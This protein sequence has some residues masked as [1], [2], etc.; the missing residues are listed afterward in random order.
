MVRTEADVIVHQLIFT[1]ITTTTT[2][3][4]SNTVTFSLTTQINHLRCNHP[5][6]IHTRISHH[7]GILCEISVA[8]MM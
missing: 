7:R 6:I 3:T 1:T 8:T 4:T 2:S 5:Y